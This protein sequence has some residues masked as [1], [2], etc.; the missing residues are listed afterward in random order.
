MVYEHPLSLQD[1]ST[2]LHCDT[3]L[4]AGLLGFTTSNSSSDSNNNSSSS[5]RKV[6]QQQQQQRQ[7]QYPRRLP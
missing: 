6:Q 5:K 1:S 3:K 4:K 7:R 2:L